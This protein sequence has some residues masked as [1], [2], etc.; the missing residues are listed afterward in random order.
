MGGKARAIRNCTTSVIHTKTGMRIIVMPGARMLR[1]VTMKLIAAITDETPRIW[2]LRIQKSTPRPGEQE[3]REAAHPVEDADPLVVDRREPA[4]HGRHR[5]GPGQ[6][7]R[8]RVQN[9]T[10]GMRAHYLRPIR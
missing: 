8:R 3:E 6:G 5:A 4:E 2:R 9:A 10:R 1:I 7:G